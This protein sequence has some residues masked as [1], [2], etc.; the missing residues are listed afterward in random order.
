LVEYA[1]LRVLRFGLGPA[2]AAAATAAAACASSVV[3]SAAA[4]DACLQGLTLVHFS[5]QREPCLTQE[6]PTHPKHNLTTP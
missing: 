4:A 2:A 6:S 3:F 5:A 1:A